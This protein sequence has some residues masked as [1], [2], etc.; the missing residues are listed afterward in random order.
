MKKTLGR[1]ICFN[2]IYIYWASVNM[3]FTFK[4]GYNI[5]IVVRFYFNLQLNL[6]QLLQIGYFWKKITVMHVNTF[7]F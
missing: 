2:V 6:N 1:K 7:I 3:K 4:N 5:N